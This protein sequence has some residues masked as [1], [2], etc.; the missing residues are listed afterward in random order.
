MAERSL[1]HF[2]VYAFKPEYRALPMEE[3]RD[4]G[5]RWGRAMEGVADA[6]HHYGSFPQESGADFMT[7]AAVDADDP[8]TAA[9]FFE[10]YAAAAAPFLGFVRCTH[11]LWGF[12]GLSEYAKRKSASEIIPFQPREEP[13]L[14]VYPFAK[15]AEWY[16]TPADDRR[17]MMSEHIRIGKQYQGIGQLLVYSTGL[18]DHEFVVVYETDDLARFS[19]LVAE[20]RGTEARGYTLRD[21]PVHVGVHVPT[22]ELE[23]V[24]L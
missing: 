12:T 6:A 7:W 22:S 3:R 10:S 23:R 11:V 8:A 18:Q 9:K 2:G 5:R 20:L 19:S 4:L 15:T 13:Y 16:H 24:W 1:N 17:A 14:I 21:T